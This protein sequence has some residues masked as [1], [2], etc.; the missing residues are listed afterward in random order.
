MGRKRRLWRRLGERVALKLERREGK[1]L[2]RERER[3]GDGDR[4]QMQIDRKNKNDFL[5]NSDDN[6]LTGCGRHFS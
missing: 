3:R 5:Y 6:V 2:E 1:C 4:H